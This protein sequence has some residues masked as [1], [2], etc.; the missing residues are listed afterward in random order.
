MRRHEWRQ[1][2]TVT[3]G[4][5]ATIA[6]VVQVE[7]LKAERAKKE[8][9]LNELLSKSTR[10]LWEADL[11]AFMAAWKVCRQ[12]PWFG[13]KLA[14][15]SSMFNLMLLFLTAR[16][17]WRRTTPP[18]LAPLALPSGRRRPRLSWH[19]ALRC[20]HLSP[21]PRPRRPRPRRRRSTSQPPSPSSPS[22]LRRLHHRPRRRPCLSASP[23]M[24][25]VGASGSIWR[26]MCACQG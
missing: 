26:V 12:H 16:P 11:D 1:C 20:L 21:R 7:E 24:L 23:L 19:L 17:S 6:R 22:P 10:D 4:D 2:L 18:S 5:S 15:L 8:A 14:L 9:E 25:V 3:D 13:Y